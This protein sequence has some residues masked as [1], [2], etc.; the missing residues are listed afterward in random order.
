MTAEEV[1]AVLGAGHAPTGQDKSITKTIEA[2]NRVGFGIRTVT[3]VN[4]KAIR[5]IKYNKTGDTGVTSKR[6]NRW[7]T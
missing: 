1:D 6:R 7:Y 3:D 2:L 4:G 5:P